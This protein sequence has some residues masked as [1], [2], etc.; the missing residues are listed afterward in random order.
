M[1]KI[2][3]MNTQKLNVAQEDWNFLIILD[4]CRY[5]YFEKLYRQYLNGTLYK[6]YSVGTSTN[7]WLNNSFP[8]FYDDIIYISANPHINASLEVYGYCAGK[9]FHQVH[10]LWKDGWDNRIGTVRPETVTDR[11]ITLLNRINTNDKR[12]VVHYIQPHAPYLNLD[13]GSHFKE[14]SGG[15]IRP[16]EF[17]NSKEKTGAGKF[18]NILYNIFY[19]FFKKTSWLGNHPDWILRKFFNLPPKVPMEYVL[20]KFDVETLRA[21][22]E[23]NLKAVLTETA[24]LLNF[25]SGKVVITSDHG[26]FLGEHK[27]FSHPPN[28]DHPILYDIPWLE[29]FNDQIKE[30]NNKEQVGKKQPQQSESL[31]DEIIIERLRALGYHE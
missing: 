6:K 15:I 25:L 13:I 21:S 9:H 11:T 3:T 26:E 29:I 2:D 17:N 27:N 10:E 30:K 4:A 5:D 23:E 19:P 7:E 1:L 16:D 28:S 14:S 18:K 24:R 12:V 22:Y 31:P 20:R 8:D